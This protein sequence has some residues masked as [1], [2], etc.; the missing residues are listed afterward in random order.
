[1]KLLKRGIPAWATLVAVLLAVSVTFASV[2]FT[3]DM[4]STIIVAAEYNLQCLAEDLTT[5][6]TSFT[7]GECPQGQAVYTEVI[8]IKNTGNYEAWVAWTVVDLPA[9]FSI[10]LKDIN[11]TGEIPQN[12]FSVSVQPD[13]LWHFYGSEFGMRFHVTNDN[14]AVGSH[15]FTIKFMSADSSSG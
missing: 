12:D 14:A 6:I 4:P 8:Q 13:E 15:S 2:M 11:P 7:F 5:V 10:V 3:L 9:G 1:M